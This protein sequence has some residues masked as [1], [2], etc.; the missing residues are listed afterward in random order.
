M[1]NN[2]RA[3]VLLLSDKSSG[4]TIIQKEFL[5]HPEIN[6]IYK[7]EKK[8]QETA[9]WNRAAAF[10]DRPQVKMEYSI[11]PISAKR[12]KK[13]LNDLFTYALDGVVLPYDKEELVFKGWYLLYQK[14]G[15]IF[16]EKSPHHLH[17]WSALE[18]IIECHEKFPEMNFK[19]IGLIRNPI[20]TLYSMWKRWRAIPERR[21]FEWLRVYNNLKKFH[22]IVGERLKIVKYENVIRDKEIFRNLCHFIGVDYISGIGDNLHEESIQKWR[23]DKFFGFQLSPEV[24]NI[25]L[26]YGYSDSEMITKQN[27][28]WPI[29]RRFHNNSYKI[30]KLRVYTKRFMRKYYLT[31]QF[32]KFIKKLKIYIFI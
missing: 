4:S 18:L 14:Y 15:P 21:Q 10:L 9:Y 6:H 32:V 26:S 3:C 28:Y 7:N 22:S 27:K 12:A 2:S 24:M 11:F 13:D 1:N 23:A 25:A 29:I 17:Y 30:V 31:R 19:F 20:D 8:I 5:K 16:F